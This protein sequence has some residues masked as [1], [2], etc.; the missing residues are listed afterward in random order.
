MRETIDGAGIT[1]LRDLGGYRG[2]DGLKVR[3]KR[4]Y[5]SGT[6]ADARVPMDSI[7]P[8]L[9]ISLVIDLRTVDETETESYKLPASVRYLHRPILDSLDGGLPLNFPSDGQGSMHF[10]RTLNSLDRATVEQ[11][12]GFMPQVYQEMGRSSNRFGAIIREIVAHDGAPLLF[13]CSA[14]KDRTGVLAALLLLALGV[15]MATVVDDY[16]ESNA[17]RKLEN[18]R[19]LTGLASRM[20]RPDIL[21]LVEDMLMVKETYLALALSDLQA[22]PSFE[23]YAQARL[24]LGL[25]ELQ[26]LRH[27]YLESEENSH[28]S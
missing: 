13:H 28:E 22:Y 16:L 1:N 14:G 6:P 24:G 19:L 27:Y 9:D 3:G 11:A 25:H 5:R 7:L 4:L 8:P 20:D 18:D 2:K 12:R 10:I 23:D 17:R 15:P 26:T 21:G